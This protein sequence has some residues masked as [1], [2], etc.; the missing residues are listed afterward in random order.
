MRVF[1]R[2]GIAAGQMAV[3]FAKALGLEFHQ[4]GSRDAPARRR[5]SP[6]P[7]SSLPGKDGS[8]RCISLS[9]I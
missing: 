3:F 1:A 9:T 8:R 6:E 7:T 5:P 2:P 4:D